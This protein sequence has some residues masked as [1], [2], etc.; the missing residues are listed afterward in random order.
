[1]KRDYLIAKKIRQKIWTPV[2]FEF[3]QLVSKSEDYWP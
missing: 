2:D 3:G 1:M